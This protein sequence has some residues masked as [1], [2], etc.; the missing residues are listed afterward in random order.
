MIMVIGSIDT[1][2]FVV[3][4]LPRATF[5]TSKSDLFLLLVEAF[6]LFGQDRRDLP[7]GDKHTRMAEKFM[8]YPLA[9]ISQVMKSG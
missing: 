4:L 3:G 8:K 5:E 1:S 6:A 2:F 7:C 9:G